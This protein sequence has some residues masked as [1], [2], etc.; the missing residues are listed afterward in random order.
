MS[1]Q[2]SCPLIGLELHERV[3]FGLIGLH[4]TEPLVSPSVFRGSQSL[5]E[6][7]SLIGFKLK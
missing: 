3:D 4:T 5:L 6:G 2:L 1:W 7:A